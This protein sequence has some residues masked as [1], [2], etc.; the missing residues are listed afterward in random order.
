ME[1]IRLTPKGLALG[2]AVEAGFMSRPPT[3]EQME[4]FHLFWDGIERQVVPMVIERM[5]EAEACEAPASEMD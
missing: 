2:L 5:K 3:E 4:R 1:R